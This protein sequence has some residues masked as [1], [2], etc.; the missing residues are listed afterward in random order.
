MDIE[1]QS[2]SFCEIPHRADIALEITG[3]TL[4][5]LFMHAAEGL[6][7][8]MGLEVSLEMTIEKEITFVESDTESLLVA[9]L[10]ELIFEVENGIWFKIIEV[11]AGEKELKARLAGY[12]VVHQKREIKAA[13]YHDLSIQFKEKKWRTAIIFDV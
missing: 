3:E 2:Q 5:K 8:I 6:S 10:S 12:A 11:N 4:D 13:T 1:S 7:H 9:F